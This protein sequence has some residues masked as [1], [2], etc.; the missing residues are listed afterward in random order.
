MNAPEE[1]PLYEELPGKAVH[2]RGRFKHVMALALNPLTHFDDGVI[3]CI[4]SREGDVAVSGFVDHS[5]LHLVSRSEDGTYEIGEPLCIENEDRMIGPLLPDGF[6][7]LGLEDPDLAV[8]TNGELH[9]YCTVPLINRATGESRIYLGHAHGPALS[10]LCMTEP[11]LGMPDRAAKEVTLAPAASDGVHRH[12]VESSAHG[13]EFSAYSTVRV[14]KA[15]EAGPCWEFG[16]TI[17]HPAHRGIE[18]AAGHASPGP[19]LP[20][21][22]IDVGENKLLGFFNG[23][24]ADRVDREQVVFGM[25][26][27]G[28]FIYD[29]EHGEIPWVSSQPFIIDSEA[30]TITFASQFVETAPGEGILY[31]HVDDSFVRAYRITAEGLRR[32]LPLEDAA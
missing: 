11:V 14:A 25:F 18:W 16:E 21:S 26:S 6:E 19:L 27:V 23:R 8:D 29:Y 32:A 22:F 7:F 4:T 13:T 28:L 3:R 20:R 9:L 30:E 31:A 1:P 15:Q 24:E 12:L 5:Q 2:P 17:F 10:S